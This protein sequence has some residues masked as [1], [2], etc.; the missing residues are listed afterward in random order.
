MATPKKNRLGGGIESLLGKPALTT[1]GQAFPNVSAS[2]LPVHS[3]LIREIPLNQIEANAQQ[4]RTEFDEES[5]QDLAASI[6]QIGIVQPIT[7]REVDKNRY[8]IISGERR[9]RA[10][11]LAGLSEIPVYVRTADDKDIQIMALV[12]NIQR[13]GLNDLDIAISYQKL[14]DAHHLTQEEISETVGKSR[15]NVA[16]YLRVL[17]LPIEIQDAMRKQTITIGHARAL[18]PLEA[19]E[20]LRLAQQIVEQGLSVRQTEEI[21]SGLLPQKE[22]KPRPKT[23]ASEAPSELCTQLNEGL[24][25]WFAGGTIH[26]KEIPNGGVRITIDLK[27]ADARQTLELLA[28]S[29][30]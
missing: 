13:E 21:V 30:E 4:P 24:V 12:E 15:S 19:K 16:N 1:P 7:V 5:L 10:A 27:D 14:I 20:Q 9:Y 22:K 8:Q 23:Q 18:I 17:K 28:Q 2:G 11:A 6:E 29:G 26:T 3:P 25:K